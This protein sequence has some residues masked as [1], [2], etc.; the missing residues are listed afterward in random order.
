MANQ[1]LLPR[2]IKS[3]GERGTNNELEVL[4]TAGSNGVVVGGNEQVTIPSQV[5]GDYVLYAPDYT[6]DINLSVT[7]RLFVVYLDPAPGQS[8]RLSATQELVIATDINVGTAQVQLQTPGN[9]QLSG[10]V[11]AG[12]LSIQAASVSDVINSRIESLSFNLT[13]PEAHSHSSMRMT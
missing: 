10:E 4:Y 6:S 8:I 13:A 5:T 9:L 7:G 12:N 11:S 3:E 2:L 1:R